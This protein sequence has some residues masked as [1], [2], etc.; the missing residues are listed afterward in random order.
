MKKSGFIAILG[1]ALLIFSCGTSETTEEGYPVLS[2]DEMASII[3]DM[4]L[5][6]AAYRGRMHNDTLAEK[7]MLE[8]M[9][10]TFEKRSITREQFLSNYNHYLD[11]PEELA[12][13]YN[14]AL[15]KLSA[16]LSEVE[17]TE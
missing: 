16:H 14:D 7:N 12:G 2:R 15:G 5:I 3:Y 17:A 6:E 1:V 9:T 13:I 8:R 4:N 10:H 11:D